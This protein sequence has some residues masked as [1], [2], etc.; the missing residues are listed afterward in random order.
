MPEL[1]YVYT[2]A[3]VIVAYFLVRL[4]AR[5]IDPFEPVWMFL[6]GYS[7]MYVIQP[8]SY[9]NWAVEARGHETV[10][11]AN[12]RLF[13]ALG[14]FLFVYHL[15]PGRRIAAALPRPPRTWS[16]TFVAALSP[17]LILWG[18]YCSRTLMNMGSEGVVVS[19]EAMLLASFPFVMMD[20]AILLIVTGRNLQAPRPAFAIAGLCTSAVYTL[21]WIFNGKRSPSL[22][23]VLTTFCALYVTRLKRPSWP[24]LFS[25]AIAGS[26]VVGVAIGWRTD[27]DHPRSLM[28]FVSFLAEFDVSNV[29]KSLNVSDEEEM[30][31]HETEEYG[32]FLLMMDT[33]P[34]KS[35]YDYGMNY[36]RVFST[37]IPRI[38]WHDKPI[39]GRDAWRNAWVVGSEIE[40]EDDFA[41]PSIGLLGATQLNGG[42]IGTVIVIAVLAV[43]LRVA[44]EFFL[45]YAD[46]PWAQFWWSVTYYNA[47]L[48]VVTDD[49][50]VWFY[51]SWGF[52]VFPIVVLSWFANKLMPTT[53]AEASAPS[54]VPA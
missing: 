7:H 4:A 11:A 34:E 18:L 45:R 8:L 6:V 54:A 9:H 37:F 40:R 51:Y 47:W 46:V 19:A 23:A 43:M 28:G 53:G 22:I 5:R 12:W 17:P 27:K 38:I 3:G 31:S 44:F 15:N 30:E 1:I 42:A 41:S 10:E 48:M 52:S 32:G 24:V 26:L 25:L 13:W 2:T 35:D 36:I 21:M 16:P 49:P 33:V 39:Y 50:M 29:S 20:A 14:W